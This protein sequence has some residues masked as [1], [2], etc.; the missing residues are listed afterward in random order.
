MKSN[1]TLLRLIAIFKFL[2]AILLI[3]VGVGA[4][5]LLHGDA[6]S[7]LEHWVMALGLDPGNRFVERVLDKAAGLTPNNIKGLG[8]GSFMYAALFLT[9]GV[10]LWLLKRW[11]EWLTMI[12]TS[13]LIPV[14]IYEIHR[15]ATVIKVAVLVLN[16]AIAAYLIHRLR[17]DR[18]RAGG[19]V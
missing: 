19:S 1:G 11:A 4:F 5:K 14:E 8:I 13:S 15:H 7:L 17:R 6:A 16:A 12:I 9:E 18:P 2:K 10:G 3:G